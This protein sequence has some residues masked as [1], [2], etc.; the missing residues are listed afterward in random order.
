MIFFL[1]FIT[2]VRG[3]S[4][5]CWLEERRNLDVSLFMCIS[6]VSVCVVQKCTV[7]VQIITFSPDKNRVP[8]GEKRKGYKS[9]LEPDN[10]VHWSRK[11]LFYRRCANEE[12][13][14]FPF[15]VPLSRID[16]TL[17]GPVGTYYTFRNCVFCPQSA[18]VCFY[19]FLNKHR[20]FRWLVFMTELECV[21]WAVRTEDVIVI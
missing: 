1:N 12:N 4:C 14:C 6:I 11:F 5:D 3:S 10:V 19:R 8:L 18:S 17:T 15:Q 9:L 13:L 7:L 2:C 21:F 20:L 16:L